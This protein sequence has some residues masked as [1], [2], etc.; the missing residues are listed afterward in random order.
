M[1]TDHLTFAERG[2]SRYFRLY[3]WRFERDEFV[4]AAYTGLVVAA[5][6]FDPDRGCKFTTYAFNWIEQHLKRMAMIERRQTGWAYR[7][8]RAEAAA[9]AHGMVRVVK[10]A[11]WPAVVGKDGD[12]EPFDVPSDADSVEDQVIRDSEQARQRQAILATAR[13]PRVRRMLAAYLDGRTMQEIA[14]QA[15]LTRSRVQQ[16]LAP[17]LERARCRVAVVRADAEATDVADAMPPVPDHV[18][19]GDR[20]PES[21]SFPNNSEVRGATRP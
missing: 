12:V 7:P 18:D 14:D 6:K 8:T 21:S 5:R 3:R 20:A 4:S 13:T 2:A 15:G 10:I 11:Q 16:I 1:I 9:G 17:A 19:G